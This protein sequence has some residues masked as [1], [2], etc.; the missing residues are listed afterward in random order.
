MKKILFLLALLFPVAVHA[1]TAAYSGFCDQGATSATTSGLNS[2]NKLQGIIPY[3]NVEVYLT[4]TLTHATIYKDALNTSQTNPYRT[5][6]NGQITFYAATGQGYD[7]VKSGGIYPLTYSTPLTVTGWIS[8]GYGSGTVNSGLAGEIG[9]YLLNGTIISGTFALPNGITATTQGCG[10]NL[11]DVA[12]GQYVANCVVPGGVT[13][14]S[15]PAGNWPPWLVP[16][17][18]NPTTTPQLT[19]IAGTVPIGNGG[20]GAT[21]A[22]GAATNLGVP[23]WTIGVGA[24]SATCSAIANNGT[25]YTSNTSDIF[26]CS[27]VTGTYQ[28]NQLGPTLNCAAA[29]VYSN[30]LC[31]GGI[32]DLQPSFGYMSFG[33]SSGG[34]A[35]NVTGSLDGYSWN[36]TS[37]DV[38]K[39]ISFNKNSG[40]WTG[41]LPFV[42]NSITTANTAKIA[43]V[44]DATH[45]TVDRQ[46]QTT[47]TAYGIWGTDNTPAAHA[48][49]TAVVQGNGGTCAWLAGHYML[50]T[51]DHD[52]N[53]NVVYAYG[54]L[55]QDSGDYQ[56]NAGGSGATVSCTTVSGHLNACTVTGGGT[57]YPASN[58]E[59][60]DFGQSASSWLGCPTIYAGPCGG[61]FATVTTDSSGHVQNP[62]TIVYAGFGLTGTVAPNVIPTGGDGEAA[63]CSLTGGTCG[64]PTI[65]NAGGG[66]PTSQTNFLAIHAFNAGGSTCSTVG[67]Y[68]GTNFVGVGTASSNSSG[69]ISSAVWTTAPTGCGSVAPTIVFGPFACWDSGTSKFDAQCTNLSP[70]I[71]PAIPIQVALVSGASTF[72]PTGSALQGA[73]VFSTWDGVTVD[74]PTP[75]VLQTQSA[76]FGGP[77]SREDVGNLEIDSGFIG[78]WVTNNAN[79]GNQ[80]D[81]VFATG[82]GILSASTDLG[83]KVS[84]LEFDSGAPYVNG[85]TWSHR[86][87]FPAGA[88]G[89]N[90]FEGFDNMVVEPS[91]YNSVYANLDTWFDKAVWHSDFTGDAVDMPETCA[92]P[93]GIAQR[94]TGP[95]FSTPQGANAMC[96]KGITGFGYLN[97]ARDNR[98]A[99][100]SPLTNLNG[101]YLYRPIF[102][103]SLGPSPVFNFDCEG[104]TTLVSDPY[105]V[106]SVQ[107]GAMEFS[108]GTWANI[109]KVYWSG[110]PIL[111]PLWNFQGLSTYGT[112]G[113]PIGTAWSEIGASAPVNAQP[114]QNLNIQAQIQ[115]QFGE[116]ITFNPS[117]GIPGEIDF[118][119]Q[120]NT[121]TPELGGVIKPNGYNND[122]Y[123]LYDGFGNKI[124]DIH[125]SQISLPQQAA[126][127]GLHQCLHTDD[128]GIVTGTGS[129]CGS[130]GGSYV[131][132]ATTTQQTMAGNLITPIVEV[133]GPQEGAPLTAVN[134]IWDRKNVVVPA[135]PYG[136]SEVTPIYDSTCPVLS[137]ANCF[138][139][140]GSNAGGT[141]AYTESLNGQ[142]GWSAVQTVLSTGNTARNYVVKSGGYYYLFGIPQP[143]ATE[144]DIYRSANG[145]SGWSLV[146]SSAVAIGSGGAWDAG[147]IGSVFVFQDTGGT[148][149]LYYS[150]TGGNSGSYVWVTGLAT[151]SSIG[152]P[153][154]KYGGNPTMGRA[155]VLAAP[156][157]NYLTAPQMQ[158][159]ED[160]WYDA[161]TSLYWAWCHAGLGP[162]A[163]PTA[164]TRF[165]SSDK[166]T[167]TQNPV[168]FTLPQ[169]SVI[170]DGWGDPGGIN[171]WGQIDNLHILRDS[172]QNPYLVGG[173]DTYLYYDCAPSQTTIA[174]AGVCLA[175][176]HNMNAHAIVGTDE[177]AQHSV[178]STP[179]GMIYPSSP[180][181]ANCIPQTN[182]Y[183]WTSCYLMNGTGGFLVESTAPEINNAVF[184]G[185]FALQNPLDTNG[186]Y[187][188]LADN[189]GHYESGI[190][191]NSL[192]AQNYLIHASLGSFKITD[193]AASDTPFSI[194][195]AGGMVLGYPTASRPTSMISGLTMSWAPASF[196]SP[197]VAG[198][199]KGEINAQN[200]QGNPDTGQLLLSA[201]G[202]THASFKGWCNIGWAGTNILSCG[203]ASNTPSLTLDQS[204]D[205]SVKGSITPAASRKG[206]FICTGGGTITITNSNYVSN[207]DVIITMHTAGGT[208]T[209]PPAFKT[210]T[211]ATGF[212]VLCGA[213]DTSTY[214]YDVLN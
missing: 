98:N 22:Y 85:G 121:I 117:T 31:Y 37:A 51:Y 6:A 194:T 86:S 96:Y 16:T 140:W 39:Y 78:L 12:T 165:S 155:G 17:V 74:T 38:G 25:F 151:A 10:T 46:F 127:S 157:T 2:T 159:C 43:S 191:F 179:A 118:L 62:V 32:A 115:N 196:A 49:Y 70:L 47:D 156:G 4:G 180:G 52:A 75:G 201:G 141:V 83:L 24:P 146:T 57:N 129:D 23:Q 211:N 202:G 89:I 145:Y 198:A 19:L 112:A 208:I 158:S 11:N 116:A 30:I 92:T 134:S 40:A 153:Y 82:I 206:T 105:R 48:C 76:M 205:L 108:G 209:T 103:G 102:Y 100:G 200:T 122:G 114:V 147:Q 1:Q 15:A 26:Q 213:T 210:V 97:L 181:M 136:M 178:L 34:Y 164:G 20:T 69:G 27:N 160:F 61:E 195:T 177:G 106:E 111:Q 207:S 87:D 182:G 188:N 44:I 172:S 28:W 149:D 90:D 128:N 107:E 14:F 5:T 176:A 58:T 135:V 171:E 72:A 101:K 138:R 144:I 59:I 73:S 42:A 53:G 166:H 187:M 148:W 168:G 150:A 94:Q 204:G 60:L 193:S 67:G 167:W 109:N 54:G 197:T 203:T 184:D 123:G 88:G 41:G 80:H 68:A 66:H 174:G 185:T 170:P 154:T 132:T 81:M 163:N 36:F 137:S 175:I 161:A 64:T 199:Q 192:S 124:V 3:C 35:V 55:A 173:N 162:T 21:T 77:Y 212:S 119:N 131:S 93:M 13:I 18:T 91:A 56:T 7:I 169:L 71:P 84:N 139:L 189:L 186:S 29:S 79:K 142:T 130:G 125:H 65:T 63:T 133:N 110:S 152:G 126:G 99:G 120:S 45:F 33:W 113:S 190:G 183:Q 214:N 143:A 104:C 9:Y 95:S 50:A 8:G